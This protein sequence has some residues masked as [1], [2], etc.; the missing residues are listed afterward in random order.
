MKRQKVDCFTPKEK[1]LF[2]FLPFPVFFLKTY[3]T[4]KIAQ[5]GR[6]ANDQFYRI[7]SM[8]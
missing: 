8:G 7:I 5:Y 2:F 1:R 4:Q 3:A 6:V